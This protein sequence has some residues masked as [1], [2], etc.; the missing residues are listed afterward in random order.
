L[1]LRQAPRPDYNGPIAE[2]HQQLRKAPRRSIMKARL[3]LLSSTIAGLASLLGAI[4][5]H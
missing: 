1:A 3:I 4:K 5:G 2:P